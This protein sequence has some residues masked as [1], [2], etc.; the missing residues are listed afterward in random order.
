[1]TDSSII[2]YTIKNKI[3][4]NSFLWNCVHRSTDN[5]QNVFIFIFL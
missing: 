4:I 1:L 3:N 5:L 2:Y